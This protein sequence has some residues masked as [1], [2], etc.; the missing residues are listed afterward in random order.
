MQI[1]IQRLREYRAAIAHEQFE[2]ARADLERVE[3]DLLLEAIYRH[4]GFDFRNYA[5]ASLRRPRERVSSSVSECCNKFPIAPGVEDSI[6]Q[7]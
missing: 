5:R 2:A 4:Y 1:V 7:R 3:I 6:R